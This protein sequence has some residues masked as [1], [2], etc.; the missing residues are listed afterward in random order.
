[1]LFR[2]RGHPRNHKDQ[3]ARFKLLPLVPK[4]LNLSKTLQGECRVM[5]FGKV[6]MNNR[7]ETVLKPVSY[8]EFIAVMEE[9]RTK[10]VIKQIDNGEKFFW[11]V[12]PYWKFNLNL[13]NK[14]KLHDGD[15]E[16]E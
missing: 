7:V 14:R 15:L 3:Y 2:N 13:D 12:I 16:N 11:S 8:Y 5:H 6:R 10:I 9:V 4:I 1:M